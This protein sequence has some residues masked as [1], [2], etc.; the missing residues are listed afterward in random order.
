MPPGSCTEHQASQR[1]AGHYRRSPLIDF[2]IAIHQDDT[3]TMNG[4]IIGTPGYMA[5]E[6]VRGDRAQTASDLFSLGVLLYQTVE[7]GC[8]PFAHHN[9]ADPNN[10]VLSHDPLLPGCETGL[11]LLIMRLLNGVS[12]RL[13]WP[14]GVS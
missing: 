1:H 3:L 12:P 14:V 8:S 10:A 5:P 2:G 13:R 6:R 11:A 7:G 4:L 9:P